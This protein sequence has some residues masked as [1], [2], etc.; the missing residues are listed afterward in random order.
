MQ[1]CGFFSCK[2]FLNWQYVAYEEQKILEFR[3]IVVTRFGLK[4]NKPTAL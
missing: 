3:K 4:I 2:R 1:N